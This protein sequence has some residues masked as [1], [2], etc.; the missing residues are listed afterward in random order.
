MHKST[1]RVRKLLRTGDLALQHIYAH[2]N[3]LI[4]HFYAHIHALC[5]PTGSA[6][7]S[8]GYI[9]ENFVLTELRARVAY[10]L[11]SWEQVYT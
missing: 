5:R 4:Y 7:E 3:V 9:A 8:Q 10:P 2:I 1:R 11:Y 6:H